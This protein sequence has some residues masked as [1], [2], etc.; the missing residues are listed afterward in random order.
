VRRWRAS[1]HRHRADDW[2]DAN[3][4]YLLYQTLAG[5]WPL[6][7]D[8]ATAYM[9]KAVREAKV[10]TSWVAPNE[11]FESG[12]RRFV[13]AV[14]ADE[15]F[16]TDLEAFVA[17]LVWPGRVT[18]MAQTLVKLTAPGVPDTYQGTEL[19]DL[20]LVDPDNRRPVD[21]EARAEALAS[22]DRLTI[23]EVVAQADTGLPKLL[24]TARALQLRRSRPDAFGPGA[25]RPLA[26]DDDHW[27]GFERGGSV[28]VVVPRFALRTGRPGTTIP[29]AAGAWRNVL[30]GDDVDGGR[31]PAETLVTR[32]PVALLERP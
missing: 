8:R 13:Q 1:N 30:T 17:P 24:V 22:L 21:F 27:F 9:E 26:I 25:Y 16:T 5:A 28:A 15:R 10:H 29:L 12:V 19:W 3:T 6:P 2:P 23:E 11:E 32:F 31:V 7:V 18:A 14:L 4:E 20:S